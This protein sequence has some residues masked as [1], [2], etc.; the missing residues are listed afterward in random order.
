M[1]MHYGFDAAD[2]LKKCPKAL[3]TCLQ[4]CIKIHKR[5]IPAWKNAGMHPKGIYV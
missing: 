5:K 1:L 4:Q 2:K 3:Q